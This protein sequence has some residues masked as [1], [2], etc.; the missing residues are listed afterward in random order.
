VEGGGKK[1]GIPPFSRGGR[2]E[3]REGKKGGFLLYRHTFVWKK[4]RGSGKGGV[5]ITLSITL[6]AIEGKKGEE[7][8]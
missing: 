6:P 5:G 4:E 2:G 7:E 3:N 8:T 1:K